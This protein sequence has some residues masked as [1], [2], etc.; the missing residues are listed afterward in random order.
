H[1]C[2]RLIC[3]SRRDA[4]ADGTNLMSLRRS[5]A[6]HMLVLTFIPSLAP[7]QN[8]S[9]H[10][11]VKSKRLTTPTGIAFV[12]VGELGPRPAPTLFM[13]DA[14]AQDSVELGSFN[15][16]AHILARD[17]YLSVGI[18]APGHG[19]DIRPGE[20][21]GLSAWRARLEK[22]EDFLTGFKQRFTA[23]LDY[24]VKEEYSDSQS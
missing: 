17:G 12:L 19:E 15:T 5:A 23:V 10:A 4:S 24:L 8:P 3:G 2:T 14:S 11:K 21:A 7:G 13:F 20:P 16:L 6:A 1:D 18:D 9:D 22:G